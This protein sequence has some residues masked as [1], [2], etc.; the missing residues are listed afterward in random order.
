[1]F[2]G[3]QTQSTR[4]VCSE[5]YSGQ[6]TKEVHGGGWSCIMH[7]AVGITPTRT[8]WK[9]QRLKMSFTSRLKLRLS[10]AFI[11]FDSPGDFE[12]TNYEYHI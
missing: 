12:W 7:L 3:I 6:K 8:T 5:E 2:W 9:L 4:T 11:D 1:M 10:E